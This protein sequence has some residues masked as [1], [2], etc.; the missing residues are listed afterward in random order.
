MREVDGSLSFPVK[1]R[2]APARTRSHSSPALRWILPDA[3]KEIYCHSGN[4]LI[5]PN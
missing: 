3:L 1:Q 5:K 4:I 2:F